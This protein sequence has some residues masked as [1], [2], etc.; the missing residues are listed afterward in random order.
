MSGKDIRKWDE[1]KKAINELSKGF[2]DNFKLVIK[3]KFPF[4]PGV[5]IHCCGKIKAVMWTR[6]MG[7]FPRT[8]RKMTD[9]MK[10]SEYSHLIY[11]K[12]N[13]CR[14]RGKKE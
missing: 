9:L 5:D 4:D 10:E 1:E 11:I 14:E 7:S 13:V 8:Q 12:M 6:S 2:K 3:I